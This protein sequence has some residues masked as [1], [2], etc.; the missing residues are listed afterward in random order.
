M[1]QDKREEALKLLKKELDQSVTDKKIIISVRVNFSTLG[2]LFEDSIKL[3]S[4]CSVKEDGDKDWPLGAV[5]A[6]G[7]SYGKKAFMFV[8]NRLQKGEIEIDY[9]KKIT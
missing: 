9:E 2:G 7:G 8:Y 1:D 6:L 4:E 5:M 3:V